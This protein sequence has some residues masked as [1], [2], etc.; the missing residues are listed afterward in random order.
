MKNALFFALCIFACNISGQYRLLAYSEEGKSIRLRISLESGYM[1]KTYFDESRPGEYAFPSKEI[2]IGIPFNSVVVSFSAKILKEK[3]LNIP[4]RFNPEI[5]RLNDSVSFYSAPLKLFPANNGLLENKGYLEIDNIKT[6]HLKLN[7]YDFN[8]TTKMIKEIEEVEVKLILN[9]DVPNPLE[10]LINIPIYK[11]EDILINRIYAYRFTDGTQH[12]FPDSTGDWIVYNKEYIKIKTAAYDLYR[13]SYEDLENLNVN[14]AGINPLTIN[15]YMNGNKVP[16]YIHGESNGLFEPGE[17]IEFCGSRNLGEAY[18]EISNYNEGYNEFTG[19]YSDTSVLWLTWGDTEP[20]R[21]NITNGIMGGSFDTL[22]YFSSTLHIEKNNWFDFSVDD[23][24]RRELPYRVENKTWGWT[25][26]GVGLKL[27][28]FNIE[29]VYPGKPVTLYAKYQSY[30]SSIIEHS[31]RTGIGLN[32]DTTAYDLDFLANYQQKVNKI[33]LSSDSLL[34]GNNIFKFFSYPTASPINSIFFDWYEVIYPKYLKM[35]LDS[36]CFRFNFLSS[37]FVKSILISDSAPRDYSIWRSGKSTEKYLNYFNSD[38]Y[39]CLSD[40]ISNIDNFFIKSSE[41]IKTPLL[42]S[43]KFFVNLRDTTEQSDY[44]LITSDNFLEKAVQYS[45]F[46][47]QTYDIKA[48][49]INVNDIYDEFAYGNF[50]PEAIKAFLE[51]AGRFWRKPAPK[52]VF[53]VGDCTYDYHSNKHNF[54]GAPVMNNFVPSFGAPVSDNWFVINDTTGAMIQTMNIGRLPVNTIR[55]FENYFDKHRKYLNKNFDNWNKKYLLFSGGPTDNPQQLEQLKGVH[56]SIL[57]KLISPSPTGG[58]YKH[59]YKTITPV[60]SF[61]PYPNEEVQNAIDSS[62]ILISYLGHSGTQTWDNGIVDPGQLHTPLQVFP[63]ITDFGCSTGKFAEP[64]IVS[65]SELFTADEN[66]EAIAY[67]GNSSLGFIS[68]STIYPFL[69]FKKLLVD[70]V[71]CISEAHS[72]AK[73]EMMQSYGSSGVFKLFALTN[74]LFGDPIISLPVP[75]KPNL[76]FASVLLSDYYPSENEDS[77]NI[78]IIYCNSGRFSPHD[79]EIR[80]SDEMNAIMILDTIMMVSLPPSIDTLAFSLPILHKPGKHSI[81]ILLDSENNIDEIYE[82]DNSNFLTFVVNSSSI[83][84]MTDYNYE[85]G[86][87]DSIILLSSFS[88]ENDSVME[89]DI[90]SYENYSDVQRYLIPLDTFSTALDLKGLSG[91]GRR[92]IRGKIKGQ[93]N[94]SFMKSIFIGE[95]YNYLANDSTCFNKMELVNLTVN[96]NKIVLDT[97]GITFII[98]SAGLHDGKTAV[99][100]RNG[101]NYV[102][103]GNVIGHHVCV[104]DANTYEFIK[105]KKFDVFG[106]GSEVSSDYYKFLDTL[107]S[108]FLV[109]ITISDEGRIITDSLIQ[110]IKE[111]G[112]QYID[113]LEF[114][115]SWAFI[116]RKGMTIGSVPEM[117]HSAYSGRVQLDTCISLLNKTGFFMTPL[118]GPSHKW[119]NLTINKTIH[120]GTGIKIRIIGIKDSLECDTLDFLNTDSTLI[121]I[122]SINYKYIKL[123]GLVNTDGIHIPDLSLIGVKYS[124]PPEL[125]IGLRGLKISD[126]IEAGEINSL[127]FYV[128]NAGDIPAD[129]VI[130]WVQATSENYQDT[131]YPFLIDRLNAKESKL[132]SYSY[133]TPASGGL[134]R[135]VISIDPENHV[136]EKYEDNNYLYVPF[137]VSKDTAPPSVKL[138]FDKREF[139]SGDYVSSTPEIKIELYDSSPL[140]VSDPSSFIIYLDNR[141]LDYSNPSDTLNCEYDSD[142]KV[143]V[144]YKALLSSGEHKLKILAKDASGNYTDSD[145]TEFLF[146]VDADLKLLNVYNYPNPF[147]TETNFTFTLSQ[148]PDDLHINIFTAAG[149]LIKKISP[150]LSNLSYGFNSIPWDGT[151][152]DGNAVSNGVYLYKITCIKDGRTESVVQ[153]MAKTQ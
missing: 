122:S 51:Y 33:I 14:S 121:D 151:D 120:E 85:N 32:D 53:I 31:H 55:E 17:Y 60:T 131:I 115:S 125:G 127:S 57:T 143:R 133:T 118:I 137:Y 40:T 140:Y 132:I 97:S 84:T 42:D 9:E 24:I 129:T 112:S 11:T 101:E 25:T 43:V 111:F 1:S 75:Q 61:G 15:L 16:I 30:A 117:F 6:I 141:Q 28:D 99:I 50:N 35:R 21:V 147:S 109:M 150:A 116:G 71:R 136:F 13:I 73:L 153:K 39:L 146:Y 5:I 79:F 82:N 93:D 144:I 114:R 86:T 20:L 22:R 90:S 83:R 95:D 7:Q 68:T 148:I 67:I 149:R 36:I 66:G 124:A 47:S 80:I 119:Q 78:K 52:Y 107:N 104:F 139:I 142:P 100:S 89:I 19:I 145:H 4:P 96:Q 128:T 62:A 103:M 130:I 138:F 92:W 105:Y 44:L 81:S 26:L 98:I 72:L 65:F 88:S 23:I 56:D 12:H 126:T 110:K 64:D 45:A 135:F 69:F 102:P 29:D 48:D 76:S 63:L 8:D 94:F 58:M 134:M 3:S 27:F 2:M 74:T 77:L 152:E 91:A 10:A 38:G 34:N 46:I 70:S 59:F 49:V 54:Q 123:N 18:H 41:N 87:A 37:A 113:S 106:G 108:S